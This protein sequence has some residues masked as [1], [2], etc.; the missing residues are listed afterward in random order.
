MSLKS[1]TRIEIWNNLQKILELGKFSVTQDTEIHDPL[2][3]ELLFGPFAYNSYQF[4]QRGEQ[5]GLESIFQKR[6]RY[7][8]WR[9]RP[10]SKQMRK[11]DFWLRVD[12]IQR[13][14]RYKRNSFTQQRLRMVHPIF[15]TW[16]HKL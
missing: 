5:F 6:V 9:Y 12:R 8:Q 4:F 14:N 15:N 10:N 13:D 3:F 2:I 7:L 11:V 1:E 16:T